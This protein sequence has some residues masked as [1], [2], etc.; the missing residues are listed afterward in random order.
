MLSMPLWLQVTWVWG[1]IFPIGLNPFQCDLLLYALTTPWAS[2]RWLPTPPPPHPTHTPTHFSVL[3]L[4]SQG[5]IDL[6]WYFIVAIDGAIAIHPCVFLRY[7]APSFQHAPIPRYL[8]D[9]GLNIF[10]LSSYSV[11]SWRP[12]RPGFI[13]PWKCGILAWMMSPCQH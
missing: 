5:G 8:S 1:S 11:E 2:L 10:S 12:K 4:L 6:F 7:P 13:E 9:V 3:G